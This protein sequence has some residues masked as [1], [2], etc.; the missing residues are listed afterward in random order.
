[1]WVYERN[2]ERK[3]EQLRELTSPRVRGRENSNKTDDSFTDKIAAGKKR[4]G[5]G[6]REEKRREEERRWGDGFDSRSYEPPIM[7]PLISYELVLVIIYQRS[8][9][10]ASNALPLTSDIIIYIN[11]ANSHT[12]EISPQFV[13]LIASVPFGILRPRPALYLTS[14]YPVPVL[15]LVTVRS[16]P[17]LRHLRSVPSPRI[18]K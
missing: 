18:L 3:T 11:P 14:D 2:K 10:D 7:T 13:R 16:G 17:T 12:A 1:M 15:F 4:C 5:R 9:G 6:W 8:R